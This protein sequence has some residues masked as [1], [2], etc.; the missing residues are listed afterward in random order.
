M[1]LKTMKRVAELL[2]C[3]ALCSLL[4]A[5]GPGTGGTGTGPNVGAALAEGTYTATLDAAIHPQQPLPCGSRCAGPL[6][7]SVSDARVELNLP[8]QRFVH[9]GS[10]NFDAE[11]R[12]EL[13]GRWSARVLSGDTT[14]V[15]EQSGQLTL[16][17]SLPDGQGIRLELTLR[18]ADGTT[19]LGPVLLAQQPQAAAPISCLSFN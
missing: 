8:C 16:V 9:E 11:G 17:A 18:G 3:L 5:C 10:W 1:P 12:A 4:V 14:A 13:T 6:V 15:Q 19:L 7:L 2:A